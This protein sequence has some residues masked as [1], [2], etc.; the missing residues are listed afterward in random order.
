LEV[1]QDEV[2]LLLRLVPTLVLSLVCTKLL[3]AVLVI[4]RNNA[5]EAARESR[6]P[7][8]FADTGMTTFDPANPKR[9]NLG[10][11]EYG[12]AVYHELSTGTVRFGFDFGFDDVADTCGGPSS[13]SASATPSAA[14]SRTT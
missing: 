1:V 14:A 4:L 11:T 9:E 7:C 6:F 2:E 13:V 8:P 12:L 10:D 5:A 3:L